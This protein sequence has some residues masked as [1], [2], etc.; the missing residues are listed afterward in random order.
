MLDR[1]QVCCYDPVPGSCGLTFLFRLRV[2]VNVPFQVE[3]VS[4]V[5]FQVETVLCVLM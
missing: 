1:L 5:L 2:C 3:G 4:K